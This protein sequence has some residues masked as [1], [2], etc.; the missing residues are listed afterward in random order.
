[1]SIATMGSETTRGLTAIQF[2]VES[3]KVYGH[4]GQ[5][6]PGYQRIWRPD[7]G[8]TLSIM[9]DGY[10]LA[11]HEEVMKPALDILGNEGWKIK[12]SHIEKNGAKAFVELVRMDKPIKVLGEQVGF[13][14]IMRNSYNG[15]T[16]ASLE[17]SG[18]VVKCLNGA[19][20]PGG[21]SFGFDV[22]H[23]GGIHDHLFNITK[24]VRHIEEG[25]GRKLIEVYSQLDG[26]VPAEIGKEIVT[27]IVGQRKADSPLVYWT[28][29]IGR[30]GQPNAWNLYNGITQYLTHDFKGGWYWRENKSEKAFNLIAG[31]L[32]SGT[33]PKLET[34]EQEN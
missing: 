3:G 25:L 9:S 17:F 28:K 12:Q 6:I 8:A 29:G 20:A 15:S 31:Y 2:P 10:E 4:D 33:L 11:S 26:P 18:I 21:M 24:R 27:R 34:P 32:K 19:T 30:D 16:S 5:E 1:M 22:H 13:R 7:N 23:T 14:A